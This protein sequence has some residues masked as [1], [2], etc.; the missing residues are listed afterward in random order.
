MKI[1]NF[2]L[3]HNKYLLLFI[4]HYH[5]FNSCN[6]LTYILFFLKLDLNHS[7]HLSYHIHPK[8][9]LKIKYVLIYLQ[10]H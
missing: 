6:S 1:K 2:N 4:V 8:F 10:Y 7:I 9:T 3:N 5:S